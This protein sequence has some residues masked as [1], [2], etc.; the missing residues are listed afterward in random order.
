M[1]WLFEI[2][3]Y[4]PYLSKK[5]YDLEVVL[6]IHPQFKYNPSHSFN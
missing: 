5:E 4:D 6:Q 2:Y 1:I 3:K